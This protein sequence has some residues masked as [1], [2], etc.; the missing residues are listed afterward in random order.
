MFSNKAIAIRDAPVQDFIQSVG[1]NVN[2]IISPA[3]FVEQHREWLKNKN[4]YVQGL[5]KFAHGYVT[6]GCTEAFNEVY[7]EPCFVLPGE[8]TYHRD[9]GMAVECPLDFI[10][11]RSRLIISFPFASSGNIHSNWENILTTCKE[12]NI[13]I[14]VDACLAGVSIGKLDLNH[15]CITHVAFSFSKAFYT[16]FFRCGVVYTN[17]TISPASIANKHLYLNHPSL[18]LHLQLMQNFTSDYIVNKYRLK[19]VD[20]C[21]EHELVQSDCVLFGLKDG[22]RQCISPV[23]GTRLPFHLHS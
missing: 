8:Y 16:G 20:L 23:L 1:L 14:F 12:K 21:N 15:Q 17:E 18:N 7:K 5:D 10:P 6:A 9:A 13:K 4:F 19:Q 2:S 22:K 3:H 11:S